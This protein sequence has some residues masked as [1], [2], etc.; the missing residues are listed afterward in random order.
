[1]VALT[2]SLTV[3][4]KKISPFHKVG[5]WLEGE[6]DYILHCNSPCSVLSLSLFS[7]C[8]SEARLT[9]WQARFGSTPVSTLGFRPLFLFAAW[10]ATQS[11]WESNGLTAGEEFR[12]VVLLNKQQECGLS[13]L[14]PHLSLLVYIHSWASLLLQE[15][16]CSALQHHT[17]LQFSAS[18]GPPAF[19]AWSSEDW[20][21]LCAYNEP[22]SVD[23]E[24]N[25]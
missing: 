24:Q 19:P 5:F 15:P 13:S 10:P 9:L 18:A 1:M 16:L 17:G 7:S 20:A 22:S 2:K 21:D 14:C 11:S 25:S 8:L 6:T 3:V 4:I 12:L 23:R